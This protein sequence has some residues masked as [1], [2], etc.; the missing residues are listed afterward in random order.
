MTD[1]P[2]SQSSPTAGIA[3]PGCNAWLPAREAVGGHGRIVCSGCGWRGEAHFYDPVP[4]SV[5]QAQTALP[6]DATCVNHP[7]KKAVHICAGTGDYICSLCAVEI[8]NGIFS[9]NYVDTHGEKALAKHFQKTLPRPD[10]LLRFTAVAAVVLTCMYIGPLL[11]FLGPLF[12][13]RM[14]RQRKQSELYRRVVSLVDVIVWLILT[15]VA[16]SFVGFIIFAIVL[17]IINHH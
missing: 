14:L 13:W 6:D 5:E 3:C 2:A 8:A 1:T 4:A 10:R 17:A 16:I 9:A 7:T 12:W 15:I 11:F